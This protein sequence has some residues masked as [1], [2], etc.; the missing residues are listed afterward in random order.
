MDTCWGGLGLLW[1][2][3]G[4]PEAAGEL[5]GC[6]ELPRCL[7]WVGQGRELGDSQRMSSLWAWLAPHTPLLLEAPPRPVAPRLSTG[8]PTLLPASTCLSFR[9]KGPCPSR[10]ADERPEP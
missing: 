2:A 7:A 4:C 10:L 5:A 1:G 6:R 9:R 3:G 8:G